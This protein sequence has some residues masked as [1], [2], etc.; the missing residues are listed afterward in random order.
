MVAGNR[1]H[2]AHVS[3]CQEPRL[4]RGAV[5]AG[6][7]NQRALASRCQEF[8]LKRAPVV[9]GNRKQRALASCQE[10][11]LFVII[12]VS[13]LHFDTGGIF[14]IYIYFFS[15]YF[16]FLPSCSLLTPPPVENHWA[17][18]LNA[19]ICLC[20]LDCGCKLVLLLL[21]AAPL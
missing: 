8:R 6:N 12:V 13:Y 7:R 5:V 9:A 16:I 4:K 14:A 11:D 1:Q 3:R 20:W 18:G 2:R 19:V 17:T 21:M 10:D 15:D